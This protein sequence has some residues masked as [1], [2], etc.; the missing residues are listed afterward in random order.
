MDFL[1]AV[2]ND[3]A[4]GRIGIDRER[5]AGEGV[6]VLWSLAVMPNLQRLGI[7]TALI[8]AAEDDAGNQGALAAEIGVEAWN[9]DA[10]RLYERLGYT[11][12]GR[13][14]DTETGE[15]IELLRRSLPSCSVAENN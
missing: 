5:K 2:A 12:F 15:P 4:V 9:N 14:E 13:E 10:R 1:V 6:A 8:R 7:G 11:A 3:Y